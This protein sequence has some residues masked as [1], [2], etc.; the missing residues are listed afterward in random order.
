MWY[1][2]R[3]ANTRRITSLSVR[4]RAAHL[5]YRVST[6]SQRSFICAA[7]YTGSSTCYIGATISSRTID[8]ISPQ[9]GSGN[10][11][12]L[13]RA[14]NESRQL[15]LAGPVT[16]KDSARDSVSLVLR[17]SH[18]TRSTFVLPLSRSDACYMCADGSGEWTSLRVLPRRKFDFCI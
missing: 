18:G 5:I 2:V 15:Y 6:V 10:W 11:W 1:I 12:S 17:K 14:L 3:G 9:F 4:I 13:P 8:P 7:I 16:E